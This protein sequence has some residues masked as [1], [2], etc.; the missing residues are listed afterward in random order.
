MNYRLRTALSLCV[1]M[2]AGQAFAGYEFATTPNPCSN[3]SSPE[4]HQVDRIGD[5]QDLRLPIGVVTL[6]LWG[7]GI[8]L[9]SSSTQ[10]EVSGTGTT[11][12]RIK[13]RRTGAENLLRCG[14]AKG[15]LEVEFSSGPRDAGNFRKKVRFVESGDV[16]ATVPISVRR[17]VAPDEAVWM[18]SSEEPNNCLG[19]VG[20]RSADRRTMTLRL[21]PGATQSNV[22]CGY[23]RRITILERQDNQVDAPVPFRMVFEGLPAFAE[24][25][26]EQ[27]FPVVKRDRDA[28]EVPYNWNSREIMLDLDTVAIRQLIGPSVSNIRVTAPNGRASNGLILRV[29]S[30][31]QGFAPSI[32]ALPSSVNVGDPVD[33]IIPIA[34]VAPA[35]GQR[36]L[37]TANTAA[38]FNLSEHPDATDIADENVRE[39][40]VT[41]GE[42][43]GILTLRSK[44]G[45]GCST[46]GEGIRHI[47]TVF[48][49]NEDR[50]ACRTPR[51]SRTSV[52]LITPDD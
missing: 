21:P 51:C 50:V 41:A 33:I 47:I 39:F 46:K 48:F 16:K 11:T 17:F 43:L 28:I 25:S 40:R 23:R 22:S 7:D 13:K 35:G 36:I 1:F 6:E 27:R 26:E 3:G 49:R 2:T 15:S 8:D 24:V 44:Q 52:T 37:F 45:T 42:S 38:C 10:T 4:N 18:D 14:L 31:P 12:V 34:P 9:A 32:T 30:E 29:E 19:I 5:R 20:I